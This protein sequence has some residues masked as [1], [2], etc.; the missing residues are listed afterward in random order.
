M[1]WLLL[2]VLVGCHQTPEQ[3]TQDVVD[4]YCDCANPG[5]PPATFDTCVTQLTSFLPAVTDSC[6]Q[7]VYEHD[8]ECADLFVKCNDLCLPLQTPKLGGMQ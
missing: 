8:Q 2:V 7:C 4:A 5:A 1:R 3:K 6:L